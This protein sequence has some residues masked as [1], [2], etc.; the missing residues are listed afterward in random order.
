MYIPNTH[1]SHSS[2]WLHTC[3]SVHV[4]PKN[5]VTESHTIVH[6]LA[7]TPS[8]HSLHSVL[9]TDVHKHLPTS[10]DANTVVY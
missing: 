8:L 1:L 4:V 10:K 3:T 9:L 6:V 5:I 7:L 2:P